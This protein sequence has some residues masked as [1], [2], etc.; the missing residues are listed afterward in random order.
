MNKIEF[1][2]YNSF[3]VPETVLLNGELELNRIK[4]TKDYNIWYTINGENY[5]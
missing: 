2:N 3:G 1:S 4:F 5:A